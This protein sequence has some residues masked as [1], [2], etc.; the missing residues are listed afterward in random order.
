MNSQNLRLDQRESN[1]EF[2]TRLPSPY[3]EKVSTITKMCRFSRMVFGI[4]PL[5]SRW[6]RWLGLH[7]LLSYMSAL[8]SVRTVAFQSQIMWRYFEMNQTSSHNSCSRAVTPLRLIKSFVSVRQH[9]LD[10]VLHLRQHCTRRNVTRVHIWVK[11]ARF[12]A[13]PR[14]AQDR[15]PQIVPFETLK[16]L[17][18]SSVHFQSA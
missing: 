5:K 10:S 9:S 3:P 1:L 14:I 8:W 6:R 17:P 18:H 13:I 11:H 12:V 7:T 15:C 16:T 4:D 2:Q